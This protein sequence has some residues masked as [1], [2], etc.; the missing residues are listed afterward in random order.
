M[1]A[2]LP[3]VDKSD[4]PI[5]FKPREACGPD[6]IIRV[7]GL[8]LYRPK[9]REVL[10]ARRALSKEHD[11]GKWAHAVAGTVEKGETYLSNIL[12]EA[13]E[14]IGLLLSADEIREIYYGFFH[15]S[16]KFFYRQYVAG[17]E[18]ELD[19]LRHQRDEVEELRFLPAEELFDWVEKKPEDFVASMPRIN[20]I[21]RESLG[22]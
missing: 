8:F 10:I 2:L 14:E 17:I 18:I 3:I 9:N 22:W 16:H 11:P 4:R 15:T 13:E 1:S 19:D 7:S 12:K 5:G 6:D 21:I 20:L